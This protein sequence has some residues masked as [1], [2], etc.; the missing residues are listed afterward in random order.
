L[1]LT[2]KL[3]VVTGASKGI[4]LAVTT[5]VQSEAE[6]AFAGLH[7]LLH[8][9]PWNV[10]ALPEPQR[11]ALLAAFGRSRS[12]V[13]DPFLIALAALELLADCASHSPLLVVA[14]DAQWLDRPT[15]NTLTFVARR[16]Q[17]DPIVMLF[18]VRE[19]SRSALL[20]PG[21]VEMRLTALDDADASKLLD[22]STPDLP[23][24][25]RKLILDR[26]CGKSAGACRS[27]DR[28]ETQHCRVCIDSVNP[29]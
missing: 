20:S 17:A 19:G 3:A 11:Q 25:M 15:C 28:V 13:P 12:S 24:Y 22:A 8:A 29:A 14:E 10:E 18:A 2:G 23:T 1:H 21:L 7:Q 6:L 9:L 16:L 27:G 26:A 4:G 5:G